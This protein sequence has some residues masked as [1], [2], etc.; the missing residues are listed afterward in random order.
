M[1]KYI[2]ILCLS[3]CA[4]TYAQNRDNY[5]MV[6]AEMVYTEE[7]RY[8]IVS[9]REE[10]GD[11]IATASSALKNQEFVTLTSFMKKKNYTISLIG[12]AYIRVILIRNDKTI[13]DEIID[14]GENY[15]LVVKINK[16]DKVSHVKMYME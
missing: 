14:V 6:T 4:S 5:L 16:K 15:A 9:S 2:I 13:Y 11:Y 8:T 10:N 7:P 3:L 12:P 1:K